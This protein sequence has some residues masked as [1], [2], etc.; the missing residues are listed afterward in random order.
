MEARVKDSRGLV[1]ASA[2]WAQGTGN[3]DDRFFEFALAVVGDN[4]TVY[5]DGK[6]IF[7]VRDGAISGPGRAAVFAGN[8]RGQFKDVEVQVLDAA[9]K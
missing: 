1:K 6:K 9:G 2:H 3:Y 4:L 8:G 7:E 5:A